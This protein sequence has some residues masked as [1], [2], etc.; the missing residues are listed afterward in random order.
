MQAPPLHVVLV[1]LEADDRQAAALVAAH[2]QVGEPGALGGAAAGA[3]A[4]DRR[5]SSSSESRA[6]SGEASA[7]SITRNASQ[8]SANER[9]DQPS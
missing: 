9:N 2:P 3:S 8:P 6:T 7:C 5:V 4:N 1:A